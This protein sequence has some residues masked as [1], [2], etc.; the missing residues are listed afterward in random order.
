MSLQE[1][2]QQHGLDASGVKIEV[3]G[4][5]AKVSGTAASTTSKR[6]KS[7]SRWTKVCERR[8]TV[9]NDIKPAKAEPEV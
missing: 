5:K 6:K 8:A 2:E 3:D 4:D 1:L 7:R 9:Q